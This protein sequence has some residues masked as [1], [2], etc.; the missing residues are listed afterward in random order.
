MASGS[1]TWR[2]LPTSHGSTL[3]AQVVLFAFTPVQTFIVTFGITLYC[4]CKWYYILQGSKW[5]KRDIDSEDEAIDLYDVRRK[6]WYIS[7]MSLP[8]LML[9]LIDR[10]GKLRCFS[11]EYSSKV[12]AYYDYALTAVAVHRG[13]HLHWWS[14]QPRTSSTHSPRMTFLMSSM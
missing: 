5:P 1:T 14:T 12:I 13:R 11:N 3:L 7:G 8:K 9:I 2:F 4:S 10:W 6:S